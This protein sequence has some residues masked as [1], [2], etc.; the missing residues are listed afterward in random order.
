MTADAYQISFRSDG[1]QGYHGVYALP[2]DPHWRCVRHADDRLLWRESSRE[3]E[4]DAGH[5]LVGELNRRHSDPG[6]KA[7]AL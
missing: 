7:A 6:P 2:G 5:R 4:A 3:A 1:E